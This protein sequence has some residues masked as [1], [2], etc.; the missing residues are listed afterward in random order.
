MTLPY[1][2]KDLPQ[3]IQDDLM[4]NLINP[5]IFLPIWIME[6]PFVQF[7]GDTSM[8]PSWQGYLVRPQ[9]EEFEEYY[10]ENL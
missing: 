9:P 5:P 4:F 7:I 1:N 3:H 8:R 10:Y 6:G 2:F